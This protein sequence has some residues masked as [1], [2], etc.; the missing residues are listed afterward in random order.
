[1]VQQQKTI[2]FQLQWLD[3]LISEIT[4]WSKTKSGRPFIWMVKGFDE[5]KWF[6]DWRTVSFR[7]RLFDLNAINHRYYPKDYTSIAE[8]IER[9]Q[10]IK[11]EL[12]K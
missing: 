6:V 5:D 1:M 10:M 9:I 8:F 2:Q 7:N 3:K 12:L 4:N 11:K